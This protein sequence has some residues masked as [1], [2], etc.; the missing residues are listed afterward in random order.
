MI[1]ITAKFEVKG[2]FRAAQE[3]LPAYLAR[4]P[5]VVNFDVPQDD[6]SLLG[7]M[8]VPGTSS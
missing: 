8:A 6:W 1:F 7:E 4:T 5:R 3:E 2:R